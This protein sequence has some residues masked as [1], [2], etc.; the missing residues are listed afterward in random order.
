MASELSNIGELAVAVDDIGSKEEITVNH[1]SL[2]RDEETPAVVLKLEHYGSLGIIRSLGR[3][4]IPVYGVDNASQPPAAVSRYCKRYFKWDIDNS[5]EE[6]TLEFL[7]KLSRHIKKTSLL[8]ATSDETALFIAR[9]S[10]V[11]KKYFLFPDISHE[12][13]RKLCSKKEMYILA[14]KYNVPV[15]EAFFPSS[16][17][18]VIDY[19]DKAKFPVM[20]KGIDGG[21]LENKTGK[22]MVIVYEKS[23]LINLY[24][25]MEDDKE[26]N[27]MIQEYIPNTKNH[28]W[29]F[30]GYFDSSSQCLVA[31]TGKKLRQNPIF[32]GM[33][34]LGICQWN[35]TLAELAKKFLRNINYTGPVDIDFVFDTRDHKYKL[36]DV[37][38]RIGAS[39]R[40]FVGQNGIDVARALFYDS[41]SLQFSFVPAS[42]G[43]K[44]FVED[45]DLL[46]S[47]L[48]RKH[49]DLNLKDWV[50]SFK[51][52]KE[53]GYFAFDDLMPFI[54][55]SSNHL[56]KSSS[57]LIKKI[58]SSII[59]SGDLKNVDSIVKRQ[60]IYDEIGNNYFKRELISDDKK[61][62]QS[63][64]NVFKDS[65]QNKQVK[66][67]FDQNENWQ[68]AVY[69]TSADPHAAGVRRRRE[70]IFKMLGKISA[71]K[72]GNAIDIGCGPGAYIYELE[73]RGFN[74][75]GIDIS[76][77]MLKH[78]AENLKRDGSKLNLLCADTSTLPFPE[79]IFNL[80]LCIGV[81]QYVVSAERT[82][83]EINRITSRR[84]L[85][86]LCFENMIS[87]SNI[88]FYLH[89]KLSKLVNS[90]KKLV[91][92]GGK[93]E[94]SILSN[95]FLNHV[96]VPHL[97]KL[98]NPF[99]IEELMLMNNMKK[100]NAITYGYP[101][102]FLRR[103]NFIPKQ[104]LNYC[105]RK[106]EWFVHKT[107]MP[108]LSYSGEFY[109]GI[110]QKTDLEENTLSKVS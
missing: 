75:Y 61:E 23:T 34:S 62:S 13:I 50:R 81:L 3:L 82:V 103:V 11:L 67:Y 47:F 78:C 56:K 68:G 73:K 85:V 36:L 26:K 102:K 76:A 29:I 107:R 51:G 97:Y 10:E 88:G 110:F 66:K 94:K 74:V 57:K 60:S 44:W 7:I 101:F 64:H 84:G 65:E 55:M 109:I 105:E 14:L 35:E 79:G 37:N 100:I 69:E 45:K 63:S 54:T 49:D 98:Y 32:T 93:S 80:V 22:K 16:L 8:I 19:V 77:E 95:W 21:K 5:F 18:E 39:F 72:I 30:N 70:Y 24:K 53:A 52:V 25:K 1:P 83:H 89:H 31:F 86:V 99:W 58:S 43:R 46:S 12:L 40:L 106:I 2:Q 87:F 17:K 33:T 48:Y 38:P 28:M 4:G 91:D 20:L 71:L 6:E 59:K 15:P 27:L 9:N 41:T 90:K 92:A 108:L 96:A 42:G 104:I